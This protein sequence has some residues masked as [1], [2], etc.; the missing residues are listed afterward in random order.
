M[1]WNYRVMSRR[2]GQE[3][4]YGIYE[5]YYDSSG[6]PIACSESPAEPAGE[7]VEELRSDV[8]RFSEALE[9]PVL[10]YDSIG[11]VPEKGL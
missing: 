7:T 1:E 6:R 10:D 3:T 8:R 11:G 4:W 5:V 9:E 2:H